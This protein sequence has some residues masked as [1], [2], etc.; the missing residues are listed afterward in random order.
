ME[1]IIL[2]MVL[3]WVIYEHKA[4]TSLFMG[5][6]AFVVGVVL[7][8]GLGLVFLLMWFVDEILKRV[9]ASLDRRINKLLGD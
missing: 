5:L 1:I 8:A 3:A 4:L 9:N 2:L 7:L 6:L